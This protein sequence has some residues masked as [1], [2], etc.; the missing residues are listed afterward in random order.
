M[1]ELRDFYA[2]LAMHAMLRA[3]GRDPLN[4]EWFAELAF[5]MADAMMKEREKNE[6]IPQP[7]CTLSKS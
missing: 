6:S 5:T 1:N 4:A 2:A 3:Y 7:V